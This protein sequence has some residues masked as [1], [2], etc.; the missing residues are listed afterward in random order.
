MS[1]DRYTI[2]QVARRT[3]LAV[4]TIRFYADEGVVKPVERSPSGYRLYDATG[5]QRLELLRT[6]RELGFDL[7]TIRRLLEREATLAEVATAH[8]ELL[9]EQVRALALRRSVVRAIA[10]TAHDTKELT[11]M[12]R[13][14]LMSDDERQ[15]TIDEFLHQVFDG[16][17]VEPAFAERIRSGRPTLPDDPTPAQVEAWIE[18]A[19]LVQDESFRRSIRSMAERQAADRATGRQAGPATDWSELAQ[20]VFEK[21][22]AALAAGVDPASAEARAVVDEI[23]PAFGGEAGEADTPEYRERLAERISGG[24]DPRAERY[25]QLLAQINGWPEIPTATPAWEWLARALRAA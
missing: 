5:L 7:V 2:G 10:R 22:G 4:R 23:L 14:A 16:L 13:L 1:G 3:G 11:L 20:Q 21:A 8:A 19:E 15:A 18:L 6:L 9:D 24:S 12:N 17:D 25:W